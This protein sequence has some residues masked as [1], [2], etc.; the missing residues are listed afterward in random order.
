MKTFK[1]DVIRTGYASRTIEVQ[2]ETEEQ[3]NEKALDEAGDHEYSEHSSEYT[4]NGT[5]DVEEKDK[6]YYIFGE[7]ASRLYY[8]Y[9]DIDKL[10]AEIK[11]HDL[12]FVLYIHNPNTEDMHRFLKAY[13][14]YMGYAEITKEEY[15]KLEKTIKD[16]VDEA[17]KAEEAFP[18]VLTP[19]QKK[20]IKELVEAMCKTQESVEAELSVNSVS[21]L[22]NFYDHVMVSIGESPDGDEQ[23]RI[24]KEEKALTYDEM[25]SQL[26][27][28]IRDTMDR[29]ISK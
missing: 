2:A 16:L 20:Y 14:G 11:A 8:D 19:E 28:A 5:K 22:N 18:T 15:E 12:E 26:K 21:S 23:F 25:V 1:V 17:E 13:D 3:A 27:E 24:V 4:V 9:V 29:V 10:L 6:E 7:E